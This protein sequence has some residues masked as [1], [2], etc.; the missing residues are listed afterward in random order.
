MPQQRP[1]DDGAREQEDFGAP[2]RPPR[3]LDIANVALY[4]AFVLGTMVLAYMTPLAGDDFRGLQV[5]REHPTVVSWVSYWYTQFFGRVPG[6]VLYYYLVQHR[7]LFAALV[8]LTLPA[9]ALL[10]LS[11]ALGRMPTLRQ[12]DL[13]ATGFL[14][15]ALW[16]ALPIAADVNWRSAWPFEVLPSLLMLAFAFPYRR[17][18]ANADSEAATKHSMGAALGMVI[19][20]ALA[21]ASHESVLVALVVLATGFVWLASRRHALR[22]LPLPLWAGLAGLVIGAIALLS[23]PGNRIR[24]TSTGDLALTFGGHMTASAVFVAYTLFKWLLP[25]YPWLLCILIAAFT[26]GPG[27]PGSLREPKQ[28]SPSWVWLAAAC[29]ADLPFLVFPQVTQEVGERT[30]I[31]SMLLLFVAATALLVPESSVH[32]LDRLL[33]RAAVGVLFAAML[34][35]AVADVGGNIRA[36]RSMDSQLNARTRI[37]AE[38][39]ARGM[40]ELALPPLTYEGSRAVMWGE[41]TADPHDWFNEALASYYGVESVVVTSN[42][43]P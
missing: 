19:L 23:A 13:I 9:T 10:T 18:L 39:R 35:I 14:T 6:I 33:P 32:V 29:F 41:P 43:N 21:A 12:H 2:S 38:E 24:A 15:V 26:V 31:F 40:R 28:L 36:V 7:L 37:V 1:H 25:A 30:V 4:C 17:W 42:P 8:G 22:N 27:Q 11:L 5:L 16:F 20:G 3:A 34:L